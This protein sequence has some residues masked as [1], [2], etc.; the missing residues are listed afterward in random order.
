M[1]SIRFYRKREYLHEHSYKIPISGFS[2]IFTNF[3]P[4]SG[5]YY[6]RYFKKF[7][8]CMWMVHMPF[9]ITKICTPRHAFFYYFQM[10]ILIEER[11]LMSTILVFEQMMVI[12]LLMLVGALTQKI[13]KIDQSQQQ[14]LSWLVVNVFNPALSISSV[15]SNDAPGNLTYIAYTFWIAILMY[16]S[17][18]LLG[19]IVTRWIKDPYE[20][21][22]WQCIINFPNVGFIGIPV[23]RG[24]LGSEY[25]IY[26][27]CFGLVFNVLFYT[28][29]LSLIKDRDHS[30]KQIFNIGTLSSVCALVLFLFNI[31]LPYVCAQTLNYLGEVSIALPLMIT[32][33]T[34]AQE[35]DLKKMIL[36]GKMYG[37]TFVKMVILP[38]I[39]GIF[40]RM[41]HVPQDLQV[42]SLLM[43]GMPIAN[44]PLIV[45]A[46]KG[47]PTQLCSEGIILTTILSVVTIPLVFMIYDWVLL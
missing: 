21:V 39:A 46:E 12:L 10:F 11:I 37:F 38:L 3:A 42:V 34:L 22:I 32:G 45:L 14:L 44:L 25:V 24:L 16:G 20:S 47:W 2:N 23:V 26:V 13:K 7:I 1:R 30:Y 41:A 5:F 19:K 35:K 4:I 8:F 15:L 43:F 27:A 40:M 18:I 33:M 28:Y 36:D 31:R 9:Q 17:F 6:N 29:G